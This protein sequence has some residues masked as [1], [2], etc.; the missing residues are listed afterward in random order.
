VEAGYRTLDDLRAAVAAQPKLL[1]AAQKLGLKHYED[2]RHRIPRAEMAEHEKFLQHWLPG[3]MPGMIVGSY[4]RGAANS[5]DIDL[6]LT[7]KDHTEAQASGWLGALI[8]SFTVG[9]YIVDTL[10]SGPKKWMGY[11]RLEGHPVRRLDILLTP[12]AEF[13]YAVLYFTGSDKFNVAFRKHCLTRGY[14]LNEHAL[15]PLREGVAAPPVMTREEDIFAFVGLRYVPPT[16]RV[17]GR[18]IQPAAAGAGKA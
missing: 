3:W 6:L 5:G 2:A 12:P 18:Q 11:V 8:E 13:P 14:T 17:D 9:G 7:Y 4:R 1:T 10:V 16:E 15:T